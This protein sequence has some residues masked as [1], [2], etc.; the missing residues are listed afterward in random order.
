M[1]DMMLAYR[2]LV[3]NIYHL[4]VLLTPI[5]VPIGFVICT[6]GSGREDSSLVSVAILGFL[7]GCGSAG[8]HAH[9]QL[10]YQKPTSLGLL[11]V[12]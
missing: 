8:F 1:V 12:L 10:Y 2:K 7:V 4:L 3:M 6:M 5:I 9:Q 11:L